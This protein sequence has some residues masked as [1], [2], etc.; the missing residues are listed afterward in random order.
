MILIMLGAPGT[1]KGTVAGILQEK[2]GIK[3][4]STGDIFR[5]NIKNKTELG[6]LAGKYMAE[7]KLV[8]DDVTIRIVEERLKLDDVKNGAILDGFPRTIYQAE[9]LQEI[10]KSRNEEVSC[11]INLTTPEDEI[12]ERVVNRRVCSN[13]QCGAVYNIKLSPSK[14]EGICDKCGSKIVTRKDDNVETIKSRL[15]AYLEQTSPLVDYYNQKGLLYSVV[16]SKDTKMGQ[17]VAKDIVEY[18]KGE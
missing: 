1:G 12:I 11:V 10:L 2:L 13:T 8:P 9:R 15:N 3:Q 6:E 17:D 16:V 18:L 5:E 4:I 14:V 7:G